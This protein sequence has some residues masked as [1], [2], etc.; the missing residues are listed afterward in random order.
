MTSFLKRVGVV[1]GLS[2]ATMTH[3]ADDL[4]PMQKHQQIDIV[5]HDPKTDRVVLSMIETRPW[6]D[7]GALMPDLQEKMYTYLAYVESGQLSRDY[8]AMKGKKITFRL[9]TAFP[10]TA[11]EE[12][13]IDIV[14]QQHLETGDILWLTTT[15]GANENGLPPD[16][17]PP[18]PPPSGQ[19]PRQ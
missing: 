7:K 19:P 14:K 3:A 11:R 15:L 1:V 17:P 9:H 6:G 13:L 8:P 2:K 10:L 5:S 18:L 16:P 4:S 12:K